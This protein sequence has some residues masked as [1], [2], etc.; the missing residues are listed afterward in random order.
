[1]PI[2]LSSSLCAPKAAQ[3]WCL[4]ACPCIYLSWCLP[5]YPY[6]LPAPQANYP[7]LHITTVC[8]FH[9]LFSSMPT[10][11]SLPPS[12]PNSFFQ[13]PTG[14]SQQLLQFSLYSWNCA[15]MVFTTGVLNYDALLMNFSLIAKFEKTA[16]IATPKR[17][18]HLTENQ[19][20]GFVFLYYICSANYMKWDR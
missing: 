3:P 11:K 8:L 17:L 19:V 2:C 4:T 15:D 9:Q 16:K 6:R 5:A 10:Y 1:M 20:R 13:V 18:L 7:C 14:Y 12:C